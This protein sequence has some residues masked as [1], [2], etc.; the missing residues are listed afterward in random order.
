MRRDI[1]S[2]NYFKVKKKMYHK[3]KLIETLF[4]G[5]MIKVFYDKWR[6]RVAFFIKKARFNWQM[7]MIL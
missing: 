3:K 5:K 2:V 6:Q 7:F 1:A 4:A